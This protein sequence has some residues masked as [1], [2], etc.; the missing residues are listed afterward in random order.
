YSGEVRRKRSRA[1]AE[2]GPAN[3]VEKPS[4][5]GSVL[6]AAER[7]GVSTSPTPRSAKNPRISAFKC[8]RSRNAS[9]RMR[10]SGAM[11]VQKLQQSRLVPDFDAK[12]SS[13]VQFGAGG[14]ARDHERSFL[15][16]RAGNLGA[17]RFQFVFRGVPGQ[18]RE[19]SGEHHR[20][21][22]ERPPGF[23]LRCGFLPVH[24]RGFQGCDRTPVARLGE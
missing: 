22:G 4:M 3:A 23:S 14:F 1:P 21:P 12:G 19:T 5:L 16:Y 6:P 24:A 15:R 7:I 20:L 10:G 2:V 18:G 11:R 13:F 17:K 8:P 9:W